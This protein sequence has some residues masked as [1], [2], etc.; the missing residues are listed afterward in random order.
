M[1]KTIS[2]SSAAINALTT[3]D[4]TILYN[5]QSRDIALYSGS[6]GFT[7]ASTLPRN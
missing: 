6:V 4:N 5:N 7:Q 1:V 3:G 2:L